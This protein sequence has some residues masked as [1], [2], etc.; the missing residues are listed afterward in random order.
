MINKFK[1][2]IKQ[3]YVS[4]TY[5]DSN[6]YPRVQ[7][8]YNGKPKDA[9]R[10]GMY[11]FQSSPPKNSLSLCFLSQGQESIMFAISDD[12]LNRFMNLKEGEVLSG[13][14]GTGEYTHYTNDKGVIRKASKHYIGDGESIEL[15]AKISESLGKISEALDLIGTQAVYPTAV[16][17]T[18]TMADPHATKLGDLKTALDDIQ[19]DITSITGSI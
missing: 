6:P 10:L 9:I 13:N 4:L 12:Y 7:I 17:A 18:G 3:A 1:N 5:E 14:Y 8:S 19:T 2:L 15:L 11:G 16:G